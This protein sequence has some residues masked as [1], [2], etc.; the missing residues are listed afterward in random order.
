GSAVGELTAQLAFTLTGMGLVV[1]G[2]SAG[3]L[4]SRHGPRRVL[5]VALPVFAAAG[6]SGL[7]LDD[8]LLFLMLRFVL[9]FAA[10][11]TN[12]AAASLI[13]HALAPVERRRAL[14]YFNACGSV[15]SLV[16][17]LLSGV[18]A[19]AGGWRLP[20]LFYAVGF[21]VLA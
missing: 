17:I 20:F 1:G 18:V 13:S 3:W 7:A 10:A 11:G 2:P 8:P 21:L 6:I 4:I 14:G 5:L 12:A 19:E 9:G 16:V 15:T